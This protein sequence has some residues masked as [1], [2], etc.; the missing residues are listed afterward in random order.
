[1]SEAKRILRPMQSGE[2][3]ALWRLFHATIDQVNARDYD[4]AQLAAWSPEGRDMEAWRQRMQA[5]A[6]FVV[7]VD[8]QIVGFSDLQEDGLV[9]FLFVHHA[10]QGKGVAGQLM[11]E[12]E[13]RAAE[14]QLD[15]LY[16]HVSLTAQ[17][18]FARRGFR[19]VERKQVQVNEVTL[20]N[21]LMERLLG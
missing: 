5:V 2:E 7:V 20:E 17:P 10:W 6:P 16:A 8:E 3:D 21:A 11:D 9:D 14:R 13:R 18:F 15:R 1:M 4:Q 12:V 19:L